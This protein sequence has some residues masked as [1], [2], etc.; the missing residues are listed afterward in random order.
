MMHIFEF[1]FTLPDG[2][3]VTIHATMESP[4]REVGMLYWSGSVYATDDDGKHVFLTQY[5]SDLAHHEASERCL[6]E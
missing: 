1:P 2:R 6:K 4:D 5:E 3:E